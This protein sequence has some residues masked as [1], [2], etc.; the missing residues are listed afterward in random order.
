MLAVRGCPTYGDPFNILGQAFK[1]TASTTGTS[2]SGATVMDNCLIMA[3]FGHAIDS[4]TDQGSSPTNADL[5]D[6]TERF[7]DSTSDGTGGGIYVVTGTKVDRGAFG[8]FTVTWAAS[9]VDVSTLLAFIPADS[10]ENGRPTQ[11]QTFIGSPADLDDVWVK[12]F[13]AVRV[14]AQ[15]I[16]GGGGGSGGNTATTAAG[17]GG[18]GGGGYDEAWYNAD[19]LPATMTVH[20]GRGG[21]AGTRLGVRQGWRYRSPA[22]TLPV[23]G[24]GGDRSGIRRRWQR[25]LR[26][27]QRLGG[28][29]DGPPDA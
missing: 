26:C 23:G 9:T 7:D 13:G 24:Y 15:V 5:A 29:R 3:I 1:F 2:D 14:L 28:R 18:G 16:D 19:Q 20:A 11:V 17:G 10:M 21:A 22:R 4:A 12:P 8:P 27:R 6:V 25:R